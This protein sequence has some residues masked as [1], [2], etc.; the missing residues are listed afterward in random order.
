M[1]NIEAQHGVMLDTIGEG[2]KGKIYKT[3]PAQFLWP[4]QR[5][6]KDEPHDNLQEHDQCQRHQEKRHEIL[7]QTIIETLK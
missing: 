7:L 6:A 5:A 1:D 4:R 3:I 2:K